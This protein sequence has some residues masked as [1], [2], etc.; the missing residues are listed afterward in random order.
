M[1]DLLS[2]Q[3]VP[4]EKNHARSP[5]EAWTIFE[6]VLR[7]KNLKHT[8]ARRIVF[9]HVFD[10]HDHFTADD[11]ALE[12]ARGKDHVSRST[13]YNTLKLLVEAELV[14]EVCERHGRV[15]YEHTY[16]HPPHEHMICE[17]CGA[18]FEFSDEQLA[19]RIEDNCR[20]SGFVPQEHRVAVFGVC[21]ESAE[22]GREACVHYRRRRGGQAASEDDAD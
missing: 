16:G 7:R 21:Q 8:Q 11:L 6:R 17:I 10:R 12:L 13:V 20:Q 5:D 14:Q 15:R 22:K 18:I 19:A 3:N 1:D 2:D 4:P 9:D